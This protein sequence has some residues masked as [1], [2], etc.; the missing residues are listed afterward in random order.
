MTERGGG[1]S[2]EDFDKNGDG[3]VFTWCSA[4]LH[5]HQSVHIFN[6][7]FN[8]CGTYPTTE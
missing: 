8:F 1:A 6:T 7:E 5:D 4:V 3:H 2:S